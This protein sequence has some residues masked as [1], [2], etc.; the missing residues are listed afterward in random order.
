M[1]LGR[2]LIA[3][4]LIS[5][6]TVELTG[7][8]SEARAQDTPVARGRAVFEHWCADCHNPVGPADPPLAGTSSLERTYKGTKPAALEERTDL[9]PE[10]VKY[11]VRKGTKSM[12]MSRKTEITDQDLDALARYLSKES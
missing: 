10:Y 5:V 7:I 3:G 1:K 12:P 9:T 6:C 2:M 8:Y 11:I 4:I